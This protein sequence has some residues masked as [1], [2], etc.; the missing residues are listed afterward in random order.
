MGA[1]LVCPITIQI[2][3][4]FPHNFLTDFNS[5]LCYNQS[6]NKIYTSDELD[7]LA[8]SPEYATYIMENG[9][10]VCCDGDMLT[11]LMEENY[12]FDEFIATL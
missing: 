11:E 5:A 12:L 8:Y 4:P 7:D 1:T 9:D 2:N 3:H 10:R 6:M